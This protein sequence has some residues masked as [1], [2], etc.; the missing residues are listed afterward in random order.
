MEHDEELVMV[1]F[2]EDGEPN[3]GEYVRTDKGYVARLVELDGSWE[4]VL[5]TYSDGT[6]PD[7]ISEVEIHR[8]E[9][10]LD[11]E[12]G[13]VD[14]DE[15]WETMFPPEAMERMNR[16]RLILEE[17]GAGMLSLDEAHEELSRILLWMSDGDDSDNAL[18]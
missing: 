3:T 11:L 4:D 1:S 10:R 12:S 9:C 5:V 2:L 13:V 14:P 15:Y 6:M 17:Y 8:V 16:Q 7:G 18:S